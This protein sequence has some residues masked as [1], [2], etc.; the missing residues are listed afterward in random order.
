[1]VGTTET[2]FHNDEIDYGTYTVNLMSCPA[3]TV[4]FFGVAGYS[5]L[6]YP[7]IQASF[8]PPSGL[9][10]AAY[11]SACGFAGLNWQQ[12]ITVLP[13]PSPFEPNQPSDI[14]LQNFCRVGSGSL[15][16]SPASPLYDPPNGGYTYMA[17]G[18][19]P[20]PFYYPSASILSDEQTPAPSPCALYA[21]P[22]AKLLGL[23]VFPVVSADGKTLG[24]YD[25]PADYLLASPNFLGFT[26]SLVGVNID[27]DGNAYAA[28]PPLFHW[29]WTDTFN[30]TSGGIATT[31][32]DLPIDLGS[33]TGGVTLTEVNGVQLPPVVPPSQVATT[34]SGLA[35]SRVTKTFN[36]T[37]TIQNISGS[38]IN[39]PF[40]IVFFGLT[41]N[42][43]LA[44][45]TADL[46]G[47]PYLTVPGV[48]NLGP[49]Q[50][51]TVKVEFSDPSNAPINPTPVIYAGSMN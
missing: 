14:P 7:S 2:D 22:L 25:A 40:Q 24:F 26:T 44:N 51:A 3:P 5:V 28:Y 41:S 16:A 27:S 15:T 23:C 37:V 19:N 38:P 31:D 6:L 8:T 35:Y 12:T 42:V 36:G 11:A 48:G 9:T 10:V 4:S 33:G 49:G 47:T 50:K 13:C 45:E 21:D 43:T 30:G 46:S 39:G 1:M 20:Y 18:Y 34:A 29:S 17:P 32:N